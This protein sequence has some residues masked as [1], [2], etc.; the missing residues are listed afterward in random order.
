ML[1]YMGGGGLFENTLV[2][3]LSSHL[4]IEPIFFSLTVS[5]QSQLWDLAYC[6]RISRRM[7]QK[8]FHGD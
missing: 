1:G 8:S 5:P 6:D 7:T 2:F 4:A 3:T